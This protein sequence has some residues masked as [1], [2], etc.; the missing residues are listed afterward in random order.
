MSVG[1]SPGDFLAFITLAKDVIQNSQKACGVHA[2]LTREAKSLYTVLRRLEREILKPDSLFNQGDDHRREELSDLCGGCKKVLRVLFQIL[3]KYNALPDKD[4]SLKKLSQMIRFG[5]GEML[6]LHDI[7]IKMSQYTAAL[8]LFLAMLSVGS[9]GRVE[10][11][12]ISQG[13]EL[14]EIRTS[15][16]WMVASMQ[17]K[18]AT[19]GSILTSYS[20]DDKGFWK[21]LRRELIGE[22]FPSSVIGKHKRIIKEYVMEIGS[23]GVLDEAQNDEELLGEKDEVKFEKRTSHTELELDTLLDTDVP[24]YGKTILPRIDDH[25]LPIEDEYHK[26]IFSNRSKS[27]DNFLL[28]DNTSDSHALDEDMQSA[29]QEKECRLYTFETSESE[30]EE[31]SERGSSFEERLSANEDS[32]KQTAEFQEKLPFRIETSELQNSGFTTISTSETGEHVIEAAI[33]TSITD[34]HKETAV[35][36]E[37]GQP[38]E[39][40]SQQWLIPHPDQFEHTNT[41]SAWWRMPIEVSTIN[42]DSKTLE[43]FEGPILICGSVLNVA[44]LCAW[45]LG[46]AQMVDHLAVSRIPW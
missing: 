25:A 35:P 33:S 36:T 10:S 16:N 28:E 23:R 24:E 1:I 30:G 22:G 7:R 15:L 18:A 11:Y 45:I 37:S 14:K 39:K 3:E 43:P 27:R 5:N 21:G 26:S 20:E 32:P 31:T 6:D 4:K 2:E 44:S 46:T 13:G 12:M 17:A 8:N 40:D 38:A 19:E 29:S 42:S 9:Q 34:P 41:T